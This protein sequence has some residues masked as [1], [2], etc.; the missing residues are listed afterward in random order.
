MA[1]PFEG[2]RVLDV[3]HVLSGPFATYQ[4]ALLGAD[5]VRVEPVGDG[6]FVRH[7]G[8]DPTLGAVG[9]GASF[10]CQNANKRSICL[11]LKSEK[12]VEIFKRLAQRSDVVVE[13]SRPGV[14][15]RLGI[16]YR[17][18]LAVNDGLVFCSITGYGQQGPWRAAPSY[19]HIVQGV[20]GMMSLTGTEASG[21]LRVG[22][23]IVDYVAG[24]LAAF[25]IASSLFQ[26]SN[27]QRG[28]RG[29]TSQRIDVSMLDAAIIMMAPY[30]SD[31]LLGGQ[32]RG[33]SGNRAFSG[34][35][36]SGAFETAD[37]LL[38][39]TANTARQRKAL[40]RILGRPDLAEDPRIDHASSPNDAAFS[41]D[42]AHFC[43]D[44][45]R[46]RTAE[47]WEHTLSAVDVPAGK[48]RTIEE[49]LELPQLRA[50]SLLQ[51]VACPE[52]DRIV[53]VLNVGFELRNGPATIDRPPPAKGRDTCEIL[54]E[55][56]ID[57]QQIA[58][59]ESEG[60][61]FVANRQ[62]T[63]AGHRT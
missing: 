56:N 54:E 6:D 50:R 33:L 51:D 18:L 55:L 27:G 2:I 28:R 13:N 10:L 46:S 19:D 57:G 14:M 60:V 25:A 1:R 61:V 29:P 45:Y 52:L 30:V 48:V 4:L 40:C 59:L 31:C 3:T 20:S 42:V 5:V 44:A 7:H 62:K 36:F 8:G 24:L 34:S 47:E 15:D 38:V 12:G 37:G 39:V 41:Q 32:P 22:Y 53:Q 49:M 11:D 21:P 63:S 17:D 35:P 23:P 26:R 9:M 58:A 43:R 16:G